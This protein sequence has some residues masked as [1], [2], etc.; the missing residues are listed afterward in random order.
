MT[1]STPAL[2]VL[3]PWGNPSLGGPWGP[4]GLT[5]TVLCDR[6]LF[7]SG[8]DTQTA[9]GERGESH[10]TV[11]AMGSRSMAP[12]ILNVAAFGGE[13]EL[14]SAPHVADG[15]ANEKLWKSKGSTSQESDVGSPG[16]SL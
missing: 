14:A 11:R 10:C 9:F 4:T 13:D 7:Q 6:F 12:A 2:P 16:L 3:S 1:G 15:F 5:R 8:K